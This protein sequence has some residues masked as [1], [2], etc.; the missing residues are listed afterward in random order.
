LKQNKTSI[1]KTIQLRS[2]QSEYKTKRQKTLPFNTAI[3]ILLQNN[4][5]WP[6]F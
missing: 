5:K 3:Y 6:R 2:R 4:T 1:T